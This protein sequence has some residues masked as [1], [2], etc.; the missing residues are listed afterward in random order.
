MKG[1][2]EWQLRVSKEDFMG[3]HCFTCAFPHIIQKVGA[4]GG[5]ISFHF[6]S[7]KR[8]SKISCGQ[9]SMCPPIWSSGEWMAGSL[10]RELR[11]QELKEKRQDKVT[12]LAWPEPQHL[13]Q[14]PLKYFLQTDVGPRARELVGER[15]QWVLP[16]RMACRGERT[17]DSLWYGWLRTGSKG[18]AMLIV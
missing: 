6:M 13:S 2:R 8:G 3:Q 1:S 16:R 14:D 17:P 5:Y 4:G 12:K 7:G 9:P 18:K 10:L 11:A 15:R